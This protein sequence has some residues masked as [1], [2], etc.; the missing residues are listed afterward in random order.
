MT[1]SA[2]VRDGFHAAARRP[3][4]I[5]AEIAWR[6]SFGVAAGALLAVAILRFLDSLTVTDG[7]MFA[8]RT[9]IPPLIA[10]AILHIFE[11]SGPRLIR[12]TLILA[13]AIS[14]LWIL[15]AS[16]GR[17]ATLRA[18]IQDV[19]ASFTRRHDLRG[20]LGVH[21]LR[22]LVTLLALM[23]A[24]GSA[25]LAGRAASIPE[26]PSI[27]LF[28]VVFLGLLFLVSLCWSTLSWYLSLAPIFVV[29]DNRG[30]LDALADA[31]HLVRR[32]GGDFAGVSTLYG[33]LKLFLIAAAIVVSLVPLA[34]IAEWPWQ[35]T[36]ALLVVIT[37]AYLAVADLLYIARLASYLA[38]ADEEQARSRQPAAGSPQPTAG[39]PATP[40]T[41]SAPESDEVAGPVTS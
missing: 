38:I 24:V 19:P 35:V 36:L 4:V 20:L 22:V 30:P 13:P 18:L 25:I 8:L 16:V 33:L 10:D 3:A 11:G 27:L 34:F 28:Q 12:L 14:V 39:A 37:L 7:E 15:A 40:T 6:W 5:A 41:A 2:L 31:V 9:G 21:L 23:A 1:R 26:E 17:A 32:R 29:R